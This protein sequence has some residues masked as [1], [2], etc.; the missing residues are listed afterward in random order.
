LGL[1]H[2]QTEFAPKEIEFFRD[3]S[4]DKI[5][6]GDH[7]EYSFSFAITGTFFPILFSYQQDNQDLWAWGYNQNGGVM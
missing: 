1:D 4:I 5:Y 6:A 7:D 2:L 3:T